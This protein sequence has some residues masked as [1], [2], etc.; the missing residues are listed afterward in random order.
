MVVVV[1]INPGDVL[2]TVVFVDTVIFTAVW[3]VEVRFDG[4]SAGNV[5]FAGPTKIVPLDGI[6]V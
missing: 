3:L 6:T 5:R 4:K 1:D 2:E